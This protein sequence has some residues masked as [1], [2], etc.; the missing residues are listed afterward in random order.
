MTGTN[1]KTT[2]TTLL[3][4]GLGTWG[5]VC[6]NRTGA[7][8]ATGLTSALLGAPDAPRAA[9]EVDE[10]VLPWALREL[11]PEVVVLLNL[12]RDQL[13]RY[14]EVR[15]TAQ[16]WRGALD[17]SPGG[18]RRRQRRRPARGVRRR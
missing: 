17:Q 5:P 2:T 18:P 8:L 4:A 1:G 12:S 9:L 13:D 7:N 10:A 14:Q 6:T 16:R 11:R 3:A 15:G